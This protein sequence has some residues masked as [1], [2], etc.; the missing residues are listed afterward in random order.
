MSA[1][2]SLLGLSPHYFMWRAA[3]TATSSARRESAILP[4]RWFN[5]IPHLP[6][7]LPE[8]RDPEQQPSRIAVMNRI[9]LKTMQNQDRLTEPWVDIP[10]GLLDR[11][12]E[13]G[14]PTPLM[15]ARQLESY[16]DT[17]AQIFI[18]REDLLPTGSFKLN[19]STAQAYFAQQEGAEALVTETGAGQWGHAVAHACRVYGL[20]SVIFWADVSARQKPQREALIRWLGSTVYSSPSDETSVGRTLRDRGTLG[21]LGSAIGEAVTFAEEHHD[22]RYISGS[23]HPH[24]LLHQ[25]V[26]GLETQ[27]QLGQLGERADKL[28]ACVGGGSN[29]GGFMGPFLPEKKQRGEELRLIAAEAATAPRL[30][31]GQ[32]SYDHADPLGVTPLAKSYTLGRNYQLPETHVGGLRQHNGS[33]VVG[34]LRKHGVIEP[35]AYEEKEIFEAGHLFLRTEGIVAAPESCHALRAAIDHA[36]EAKRQRRRENIVVCLSG[37]G[38]LDL[39]GYQAWA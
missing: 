29:L 6:E 26:I 38:L 30:T 2:L 31:K 23:N 33:P 12:Q 19:S 34:L 5:L 37:S 28:I 24:V 17:P 3:A 7:P 4:T 10:D 18:K 21:S 8:V 25:S 27:T 1:D 13:I 35:Y 15:R 39:A 32:W 11:Y 16:L 20:R 9:R 22:F 36:L 14:R